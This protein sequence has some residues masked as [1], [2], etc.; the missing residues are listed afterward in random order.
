MRVI[1]NVFFSVCDCV[2]IARQRVPNN[3][4]SVKERVSVSWW[5]DVIEKKLKRLSRSADRV[6]R[7]EGGNTF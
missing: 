3:R 7:E 1:L 2:E 4:R 5:V 6:V